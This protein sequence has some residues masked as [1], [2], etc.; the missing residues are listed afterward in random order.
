MKLETRHDSDNRRTDIRGFV[1]DVEVLMT[2]GNMEPF[3]ADVRYRIIEKIAQH[4]AEVYTPVIDAA[5]RAALSKVL[6]SKPQDETPTCPG[7]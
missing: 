6:A 3:V 4:I 5:I 2:R 1:S 7:S